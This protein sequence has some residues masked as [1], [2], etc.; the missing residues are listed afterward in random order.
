MGISGRVAVTALAWSLVSC[1]ARSP[2]EPSASAPLVALP[3]R[4]EELALPAR[5]ADVGFDTPE[6]VVHDL[7]NDRYLIS[8]IV[9]DALARDDRAF[10]SRVR[11]NGTVENLR[12]I[13]AADSAV[14]LHAP[15]GMAISG[16]VLFVADLQSVRKFELTTG[17]PLGSIALPSASFVH[18]V[19]AA[20]GGELYVSDS[21]LGPGYGASGSDSVQR[22][23]AGSS[24]VMGR[25]SAPGGPSGLATSADGVWVASFTGGEVYFLSRQGERSAVERP[26]AGSL[27]GLALLGERLFVSSWEGAA[28][29]ERIGSGFTQRIGSLDAP[30]DLA[31]D[32]RRRR[33]LVTHYRENALSIHRLP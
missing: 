4:E 15:K 18:D 21:G 1:A 17:K 8:N 23:A 31:V 25:T 27:D 16:D 10:I 9:G 19:A 6:S 22:L 11:P 32:Q 2:A 14:E 24:T 3:E 30:A 29:Y 26:P 20:E 13:D 28:V 33:L 7:K 12:W 5:V